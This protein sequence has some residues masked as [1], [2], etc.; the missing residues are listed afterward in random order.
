[1]RALLTSSSLGGCTD[2]SP[3]ELSLEDELLESELEAL[4]SDAGVSLLSVSAELSLW[5]SLSSRG[6]SLANMRGALLKGVDCSEVGGQTNT[7]MG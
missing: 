2:L 4:E 5:P 6:L 7:Q 1:V 3:E